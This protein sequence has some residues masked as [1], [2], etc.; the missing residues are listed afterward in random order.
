MMTLDTLGLK[1]KTRAKETDRFAGLAGIR[2]GSGD[3]RPPLVFLHG[4]PFDWT[5]WA[6]ALEELSKLAPEREVLALDLPGHGDS[7]RHD[8]YPLATVVE[9]VHDAVTAA[10]ITSPAI[11]G[12]SVSGVLATLYAASHP[13]SHVVNV[14]QSLLVKPFAEAMLDAMANGAGYEQLWAFNKSSMGIE[15]LPA[16]ARALL[17][18]TC[19]PRLDLLA[20]Y[21]G[22]LAE[23]TPDDLQEWIDE[24]ARRVAGRRVPY[25]IVVGG[26][27]DPAYAAWLR[28]TLPDA[29]VVVF[30]SGG[31]FPQ[32]AD[33]KRFARILAAT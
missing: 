19:T 2:Y 1:P 16:S 32:L 25:T 17:E 22:Q 18:S 33:P 28:R 21:W 29:N 7:P 4:M 12:H 26:A 24:N 6:P 5:T 13:T 31:H 9:Q 10:G 3:G 30:E 23:Q 8:R 20:G 11:V 14:D 15:L 27:H